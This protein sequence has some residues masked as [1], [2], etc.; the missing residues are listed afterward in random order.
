MAPDR[1]FNLVAVQQL[2]VFCDAVGNGLRHAPA[3]SSAA[4]IIKLGYLHL[5][6]SDF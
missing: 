3:T 1:L 6:L 4:P 2:C 5:R